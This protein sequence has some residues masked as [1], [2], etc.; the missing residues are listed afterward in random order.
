MDCAREASL[1]ELPQG[2]GGLRARALARVVGLPR[3]FL[4]MWVAC[5]C[6]P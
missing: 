1:N 2:A 3:G 5:A 6:R 4:H